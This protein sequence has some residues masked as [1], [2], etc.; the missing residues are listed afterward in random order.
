MLVFDAISN[1]VW[2]QIVESGE[3]QGEFAGRSSRRRGKGGT[4]QLADENDKREHAHKPGKY[5]G[6]HR[7][8]RVVGP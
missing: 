3:T 2:N 7:R 5:R 1:D 4:H 8:R 6:N